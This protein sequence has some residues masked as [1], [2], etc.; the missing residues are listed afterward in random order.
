MQPNMTH[1]GKHTP[2]KRQP[3]VSDPKTLQKILNQ[4]R[5]GQLL[6]KSQQ[7]SQLQHLLAQYLPA[8]LV[9]RCKVLNLNACQLIIG[10]CNSSIAVKL[11]FMAPQLLQHIQRDNTLQNRHDML[12]IS[13]IRIKVT[14]HAGTLGS[15]R[16][17]LPSRTTKQAKPD[18]KSNSLQP[19]KHPL[20]YTADS[21]CANAI[22]HP[23]LRNLWQKIM[24][25]RRNAE[26]EVTR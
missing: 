9:A 11:R 21:T 6:S 10:T 14:P 12:R 19:S 22:A 20:E 7:L 2:T 23:K 17:T 4:T 24:L 1:S 18:P 25:N 3:T 26:W 13:A 8:E 5:L 16:A 15:V